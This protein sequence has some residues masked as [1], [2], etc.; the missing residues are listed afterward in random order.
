MTSTNV[1]GFGT[2][3]KDFLGLRFRQADGTWVNLAHF[4]RAYVTSEPPWK[5]VFVLNANGNWTALTSWAGQE[6]YSREQAQQV[7]DAIL[8]EP[9][10][11][12]VV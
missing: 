6:F 9:G 7:L 10:N 2:L 5:V 1:V 4:E 3:T 11:F 12:N 8:R